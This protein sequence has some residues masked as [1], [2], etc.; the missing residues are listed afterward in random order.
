MLKKFQLSQE[1]LLEDCVNRSEYDGRHHILEES[2]Y[3]LC[4]F[5]YYLDDNELAAFEVQNLL[6]MPK[7]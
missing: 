3:C 7:E 2:L 6:E 5:S 1:P 4:F